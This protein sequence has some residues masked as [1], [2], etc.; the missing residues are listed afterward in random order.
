MKNKLRFLCCAVFL[1]AAV[2]AIF[3]W[4]GQKSVKKNEKNEENEGNRKKPVSQI[5]TT[6]YSEGVSISYKK[7]NSWIEQGMTCTQYDVTITN[8]TDELADG[9]SAELT[10]PKKTKIKQSWNVNISLK[11][12]KI[13]TKPV[14]FNTQIAPG[15]NVNYGMILATKKAFSPE[16]STVTVDGKHYD[17]GGNGH[18]KQNN[19]NVTE[20]AKT[21]NLENKDAGKR[22]KVD[23]NPV[24]TH[25]KLSVKGTNI[26]DAHGKCVTL[27]G[28]S[29]HGIAWYPQYVTRE[30]FASLKKL[31]GIN[32]IRL[33]MYTDPDDG[34]TKEL[35]KVVEQGVL[36][37]TKEGL[38]VIIDWHILH[39]NNPKQYE[40]QATAFF[41]EMSAKFHDYDNVIYEICNEPNGDVTW[42]KDVRPYAESMI[43]TIRKKD[44]DAIIIVGTPTWSQDV[45]KVAQSPIQ[46]ETNIMYALHFYAATHKDDLRNKAETALKSGLPVIVSEFSIC[47]ASGNGALDYDS[48]KEWMDLLDRCQ[49]G[50]VCW[51]LSN[52]DEASSLFK[53][54]CNKSKDYTVSDLSDSGKWLYEQYR[55]DK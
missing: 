21:T 52:K 51:N 23:E 50:R 2:A 30:S 14:D 7:T 29:T 3:F 18:M 8:H 27:K 34:Y 15:E 28:I 53:P 16:E 55:S 9:W 33:A 48:A 24:K 1:L 25:G 46:N 17:M 47:E 31:F 38:Y 44:K 43:R 37:A 54:S 40:K 36:A 35:H 26:V 45:D 6:Q 4:A 42:E 19:E 10:V 32:T 12:T 49:I 5:E 20:E 22:S 41:E 13:F 39:D 11:G